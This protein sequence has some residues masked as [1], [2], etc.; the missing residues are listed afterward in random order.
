MVVAS[1]AGAVAT[2]DIIIIIIRS[3]T[4]SCGLVVR[5]VGPNRFSNSK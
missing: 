1:A 3:R 2:P 4:K 5:I